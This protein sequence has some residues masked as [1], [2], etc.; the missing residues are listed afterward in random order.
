MKKNILGGI[1]VAFVIY[2]LGFGTLY[3]FGQ[4]EVAS[5]SCNAR[6]LIVSFL[7]MLYVAVVEEL[8]FRG[9]VL[10][11][12][13]KTNINK[14]AALII[15]SVIFSLFH[16]L[17]PNFSFLPFLN[18][19]LAGMLMGSTYIYHRS[20]WFPISLHLF[21]NWFQGPV[22]GLEVSGLKYSNS[23]L[24]LQMAEANLINGGAFG[25]E[26]SLICTVLTIVA[27]VAVLRLASRQFFCVPSL[28]S[29]H[30]PARADE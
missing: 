15:S 2:L 26:G 6:Q 29:S 3:L 23:V 30:A 27:I 11:W 10:R 13:L 19:A 14:F 7:Y 18:I 12:I 4:I 16:F 25:F 28:H 9:C 8:V 17:N 5:V 21:W 24:Q 1:V 20:L 22:L